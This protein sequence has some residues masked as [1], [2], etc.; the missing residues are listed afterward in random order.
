MAVSF[1]IN[2]LA[3]THFLSLHIVLSLS[4]FHHTHG[5]NLTQHMRAFSG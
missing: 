4:N 3:A 5:T 2:S 1:D